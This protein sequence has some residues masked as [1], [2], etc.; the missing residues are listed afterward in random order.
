MNKVLGV[1]LLALMLVFLLCAPAL[2]QRTGIAMDG[3]VYTFTGGEGT[4]QADGKTFIIGT[5]TVI[6]QEP[7]FPDC[8]LELVQTEG[9]EIAQDEP[10][11]DVRQVTVDSTFICEGTASCESSEAITVYAQYSCADSETDDAWV[12]RFEPYAEYGLRCDPEGRTLMYQGQR[13]RSFKDSYSL[14]GGMCT[15]IEFTDS[16]G[17]VD[18]QTERDQTKLVRHA[19]GSFSPE[20]WFTGIRALTKEESAERSESEWTPQTSATSEDEMTLAEKRA[21]FTPYEAFGLS[22]YAANDALYYQGQRVRRF[23]DIRQSNGE[24]LN[25]GRFHGSITSIGYGDDDQGEVDVEVIRD[26]DKPDA[27][28]D[29]ALI[30]MVAE[31]VR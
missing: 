11:S 8:V 13:V 29:G 24:P 31:R 19:D 30:G 2:A 15:I 12:R 23:L 21:F 1:S 27:N 10:R 7:G 14:D 5:E 18:L 3:K 17:T 16:Q 28:G 20:G 9:T 6:V 25:S 22:Y 26:Y 4:Y